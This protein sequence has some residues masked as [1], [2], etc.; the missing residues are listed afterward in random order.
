MQFIMRKLTK[1][2]LKKSEDCFLLSLEVFNKPF[3]GY[4]TESFA[5]LFTNSWEL[6]LKAYMFEKSKGKKLSIFHKKKPNQKRKSL[7]IDEC[8]GK[9]FP[10]ENEPIRKNTEF[11][12]EIRNEA[13]HLLILQLDPYFT[14][15]FQRGLF[16]YLECLD[17]WFGIKLSDR[18]K[19]GLISLIVDEKRL[20]NVSVLKRRFNKEDR[21]SIK[22]WIE[23][24]KT[25]E[26][27]GDKATIP[28]QY[29]ITRNPK[30]A[31]LV[32]SSGKRGVGAIV[33]EKYRD[34]DYTHPYRR[35]EVMKKILERTRRGINFTSYDFEA[36]CFTQGI[37]KTKRNEY[38]WEEK[39][40][41]I[42][43]Y[44]RK[45]IDEM[46]TTVNTNP[47]MLAK[48]RKSYSSHLQRFRRRKKK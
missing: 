45:L 24:F 5:I 2:L 22:L 6:L 18:L 34:V 33:L 1:K 19:P 3:S 4:R 15:V 20:I 30:K 43:R 41:S 26:K 27:L 23:K 28:I 32:L 47:G 8:L 25:L 44:S 17:K 21:A 10:N 11:I 31:D 39:Y 14:R 35:K 48:N 16:N 29:S 9:V 7:S 46:L 36:Y 40:G 13:V 42:K 12:S 38:Y 37:K